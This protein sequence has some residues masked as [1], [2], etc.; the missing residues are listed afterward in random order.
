MQDLFVWDEFAFN[1]CVRN[2]VAIYYA[3]LRQTGHNSPRFA[4][5]SVVRPCRCGRAAARASGPAG[6]RR[7]GG[8]AADVPRI[9]SISC[10]GCGRGVQRLRSR[11]LF[12]VSRV[13][14]R[15]VH[16]EPRV[17]A[18]SAERASTRKLGYN[19]VWYIERWGRLW[20]TSMKIVLCRGALHAGWHLDGKL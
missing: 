16:Y 7:G 13:P 1:I 18:G 20:R 2:T 14:N 3:D 19:F 11:Y 5:I 15:T 10:K 8:R 6:V 9:I 12:S 17:S 4:I